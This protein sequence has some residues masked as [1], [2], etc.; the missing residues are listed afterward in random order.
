MIDTNA[1]A[2]ACLRPIME[3]VSM[4]NYQQA[5][6]MAVEAL[7]DVDELTAI[8]EKLAS[9]DTMMT[10]KVMELYARLD[11]AEASLL[12]AN[13]RNAELEQR[14]DISTKIYHEK[15]ISQK[16]SAEQPM[17]NGDRIRSMSD[18][19]LSQ[20][21]IGVIDGPCYCLNK[22]E[23]EDALDR[24]EGIPDEWCFECIRLWLQQPAAMGG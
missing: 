2:A 20:H 8:A 17:T 10:A 23:C 7:E 3:S 21:L 12:A 16:I 4:A 19:E 13:A 15:N 14:L 6:R 11:T 5:L 1:K 9:K 24:D 18:E 22:Q